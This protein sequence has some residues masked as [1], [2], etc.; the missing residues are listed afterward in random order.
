[1]EENKRV[2]VFIDA[3]NISHEY[4]EKILSEVSNYGDVTVKRVY[5]DWSR[6]PQMKQWKDKTLS[7]ALVPMQHFAAVSGKNTG[8]ISLIVDVLTCLFEKSIDV[9]CL[10]SSDSDYVRLVQELKE[11]QKM[12]VGFGMEKSVATVFVNSFSEFI[13][14]DKVGPKASKQAA[15][16]L[17]PPEKL[18][19]LREIVENLIEHAGK[20]FYGSIGAEMRNKSSD[21]IPKNYGFKNLSE[22]LGKTLG[23]LGRYEIVGEGSKGTYLAPKK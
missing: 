6:M 9:F 23:E 15:K 4:A 7:L 5:G 11:R 13:Y 19:I 1:M 20:A 2:A 12:V 14:L 17:L 22:M 18:L 21:F 3:E 10:A 8:D 16:E